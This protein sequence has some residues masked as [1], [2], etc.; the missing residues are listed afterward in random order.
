MALISVS[1]RCVLTL[2]SRYVVTIFWRS[3]LLTLLA[4]VGAM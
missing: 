2:H 4:P 3:A 1:V